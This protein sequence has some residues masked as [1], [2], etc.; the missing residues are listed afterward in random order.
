MAP[1]C[2]PICLCLCRGRGTAGW[3]GVWVCG[4]SLRCR[5]YQ[6]TSPLMGAQ[7]ERDVLVWKNRG[8]RLSDGHGMDG[9]VDR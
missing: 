6:D 7:L 5:A 8:N 3:M 2:L 1:G 4:T 9:R